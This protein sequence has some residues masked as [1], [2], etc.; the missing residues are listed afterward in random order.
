MNYTGK[1]ILERTF[2]DGVDEESLQ[3]ASAF[4]KMTVECATE[5]Q[6]SLDLLSLLNNYS[7]AVYA[8]SVAISFVSTL[9][10]RTLGITSHQTLFKVSMAGMFHDI[11]KKEID[12][13]LLKKPRHTT[14][15]AEQKIVESHVVRG[16][17][18]LTAIRHLHSDVV[19]MAY[20]HHED[21]AGLGYPN[22]KLARDQHPLSKIL[23]TA[24]LFV[25]SIDSLRHSGQ[26]VV[27]KEVIANLQQ[28]YDK[29]IDSL[30]LLALKKVYNVKD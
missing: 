23:Q 10:A 17:E 29:R 28:L 5:A 2:T 13:E 16:Q 22:G 20:E 14:T 4:L 30:C 9:L 7:D 8:N 1:V 24:V 6:E 27:A 19:R 21:Q 15:R 11:G 18:I 3:E 25:E 26:P 12:V